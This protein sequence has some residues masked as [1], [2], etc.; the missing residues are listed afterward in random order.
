M[1]KE[2]QTDRERAALIAA[3]AVVFH[4][5]LSEKLSKHNGWRGVTIAVP[6][7]SLI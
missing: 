6:S 5:A 7:A 2:R 1:K 3:A 4:K